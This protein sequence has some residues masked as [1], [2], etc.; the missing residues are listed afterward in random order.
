MVDLR[1]YWMS[2][3]ELRTIGRIRCVAQ[4]ICKVLLLTAGLR[5]QSVHKSPVEPGLV[6]NIEGARARSRALLG[7]P[8]SLPAWVAPAWVVPAWVVPVWLLPPTLSLPQVIHTTHAPQPSQSVSTGAAE[9][10]GFTA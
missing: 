8:M 4:S 10:C 6:R 7:K 1:R 9:R 2:I 5:C 3:S